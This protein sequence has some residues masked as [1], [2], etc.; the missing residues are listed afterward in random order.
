MRRICAAALLALGIASL[1]GCGGSGPSGSETLTIYVS[2]P[3]SGERADDGRAV[4]EG[5]ERAL[6]EAGGKVGEIKI[7]AVY[8][9]DTG[10]AARWD[11]VATADNARTAAE[12]SSTI[13]Y[14]GDVDNGATRTSLP[15]TNQAEIL[16][17]SPGSPAVDLTREV[18]SRLDPD[19]YRPTGEQTFVRLVPAADRPSQPLCEPS[20][21]GHE[22]MALVLSGIEDGGSAA[23]RT[24]VIDD[25]MV[26]KDRKSPIGT[27]SVDP[28]GDTT[29]KPGTGC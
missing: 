26:T 25:V 15:L 21:Y 2:A 17:V 7:R 28:N 6:A 20:A 5:A 12:D 4:V 19:L 9:D 27:Y 18:S 10:G 11:P 29:V 23:D 24:S 8:L 13:A 14:I 16:Q 22:A 3:L 1:A